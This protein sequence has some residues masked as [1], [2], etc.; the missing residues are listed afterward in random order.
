MKKLFTVVSIFLSILLFSVTGVEEVTV[1]AIGEVSVHDPSVIRDTDEKYYAF[2][3]HITTVVSDD[4]I[5]WNYTARGYQTPGNVHFGDLSE[6]LKGS[7]K[8]AGENDSDC[9]GGYAVWAPDVY[10]NEKYLWEDGSRGAYMMYYSASSTYKRS[11]IGLAVS[12]DITGPYTYVD[13][14]IY[15]G[16]T[17]I[18]AKDE[19]STHDKKYTNTHID[20]LINMGKVCRYKDD[21]GIDDY[22]STKYPNAIDPCVYEDEKGR[23]YL[24]YGS[25]SGGIFSLPL[26]SLTGI[27]V[28]PCFDGKTEDGRM[29]DRYFGTHIAGGKG[30]SGEGP[31]IWYDTETGYYYL[32]TSYEWLGTDGGYHIRMFRSKSPLGPFTDMLGN[33]AVYGDNHIEHGIKMFGNYAFEGMDRAYTSGGHC[34]SLVDEDGERYVLYHTRFK[35]TEWFTMR[36]HQMYINEDGWPVIAPFRYIGKNTEEYDEIDIIGTY[37]YI[38]HGNGIGE[39]DRVNTSKTI[40]LLNDG[41]IKGAA[42]G[43]WS[44]NGK[45]ITFEIASGVYK[46]VLLKQYNESGESVMSFSLVG[47]ENQAIWGAKCKSNVTELKEPVINLSFDNNEKATFV[48]QVKNS[49]PFR[50][51]SIEAKYE[52][53]YEGNAIKLEGGIGLELEN[54]NLSE[55]MTLSFMM[56][57]ESI[58]TYTPV[59]ACTESFVEN[60]MDKW[61]SLTT[62]SNKK[63]AVLWSRN[64]EK[65]QWLENKSET[66]YKMGK[67][68]H[69]ILVFDKATYG[70]DNDYINCKLYIDGLCVATGAVSRFAFT[71]DSKLYFGVNPWDD[72]FEGLIDEVRVFDYAFNHNE[73]VTHYNSFLKMYRD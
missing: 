11:C 43:K 38:N 58:N 48:K 49:N 21:W 17:K 15:S 18:S 7:F 22:N 72:A 19:N 35:N 69:I 16:F 27:P 39:G 1:K 20:E 25:W 45:Y 46:G 64:G 57:P 63:N 30:W 62:F 3:S 42:E 53:G 12:K 67:W 4:L 65:N 37:E 33:N 24:T 55:N 8:W 41:V 32:Q 36:V 2:G 26:N 70:K 68:Q 14:V 61:F 9:L 29:I 50:D 44:R 31:F 13:T 47:G 56:K 28:Y 54:V 5:N 52:L 51:E 73:A 6:T 34:S 59:V 71:E 23:L 10:Y 60:G 66:G 40:M